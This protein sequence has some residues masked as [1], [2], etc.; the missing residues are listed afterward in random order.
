L[1]GSGRAESSLAEETAKTSL[2][3]GLREA[4]LVIAKARDACYD[5]RSLTAFHVLA[6]FAI[7]KGVMQQ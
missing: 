5:V 4:F 2:S 1:P 7:I 6:R 3:D